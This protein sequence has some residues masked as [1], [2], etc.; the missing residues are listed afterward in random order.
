MGDE[1]NIA[2]EG[3]EEGCSHPSHEAI[4]SSRHIVS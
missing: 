4:R 3:E 1:R 2:G